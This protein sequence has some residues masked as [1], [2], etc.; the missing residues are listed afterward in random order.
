MEK[1]IKE[2]RDK[3]ATGDDDVPGDVLTLLGEDG[4]RLM[5]QLINSIYVTG[6]W[7]RDSTEVI[8]I[9]LKK[10]PK[11]TKCSDYCTISIITHAA[12]IVAKILRRR[13]ER[14]T[15]DALGEDQFGFTRG[16][17]TRDAIG[18]LRIISERTL[19]IDE[20]LCACFI[21]WQKV[22]DRDNWTKLM[23]IL[24]GIGIDWHERRL[25]SK[26]YMEH[27]I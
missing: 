3:K 22:L 25:I 4:L 21:D 11:A 12:K 20:E 19:V 1:A 24:K 27:K 16:K 10:K 14:K 18:M 23:Q 8:M 15:E 2:M 13:I 9:A 5:T 7:P 26:L 6:E 17:G